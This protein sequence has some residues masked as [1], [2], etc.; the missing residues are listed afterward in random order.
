MAPINC[1]PFMTG[2]SKLFLLLVIAVLLGIAIWFHPARQTATPQSVSKPVLPSSQSKP[3]EHTRLTS[4]LVPGIPTGGNTNQQVLSAGVRLIIDEQAGYAARSTAA[5]TAI[6]NLTGEDRQALYT[7]LLHPSP[8]DKDQLGQVLKNEVLDELCVL[9]PPPPGLGDVLE[10]M[11]HDQSQN[12]V[13]RDYAVQH[14]V[15]LYEQVENT[16]D[17]GAAGPNGLSRIQ[18]TLWEAL[19]ETDSSIAGTALLGLERLSQEYT[20]FDQGKIATT[21]L[22]VANDNS[23][24]ELSH[25]T[26]YQVCAQLNVQEALPVIEAAAQNS[27]TLSQQI[28]A[29]GALGVLGGANDLALLQS[30]FQGKEE[31]LKLPALTAIRRI[32]QRLPPQASVR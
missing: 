3:T 26:A 5:R 14:M 19:N 23:A 22:H 24:G 17:N 25:I 1:A 21:A 29:I 20:G 13:L 28:S 10:E 8:L 12:V 15:A 4:T 11:Y 7:F 2:K 31:R 9:N 18:D 6:T 32:E 16:S 30:L 27:Q